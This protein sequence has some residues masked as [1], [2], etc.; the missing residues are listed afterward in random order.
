LSL[1]SEARGG[2]GQNLSMKHLDALTHETA[3]K[4]IASLQDGPPVEYGISCD[5]VDI[6]TGVTRVRNRLF[7]FNRDVR[8]ED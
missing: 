4:T 3:M 5:A 7:G 2:A 1:G 8:L 6:V